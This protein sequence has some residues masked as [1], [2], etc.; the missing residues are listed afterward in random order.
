MCQYVKKHTLAILIIQCIMK[1]PKFH[2]FSICS[3]G[4]I[5]IFVLSFLLVVISSLILDI[6]KSAFANTDESLDY[7][8]VIDAGHGGLDPGSIG[9]KTK[10]KESVINLSVAKKLE[11]KLKEAGFRVVMTR[12]NENGLYGLSTKN[13]KK[14]DMQK[15]RDI[16]KD[17]NPNMVIS[18]HMNSYIRHNLRGAQVFYDKNS[19]ISESLALSIQDQFASKLEKS[20]K[21]I[22]I[23]D[24]YM[25]KCTDAPS[26]I[27]ECGFI[28]NEEDEKLLI[29]DSYQEKLADCIFIGIITFL[30]IE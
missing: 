30:N 4:Q 3:K 21:G 28:S 1:N 19:P 26:V 17:A 8:I 9:Y 5:I 27:A 12:E 14:R 25:L 13:Y 23:G 10:V 7:A 15:R 16:I 24:Y 18:I 29:N 2:L 20:D 22:S 11:K 6:T